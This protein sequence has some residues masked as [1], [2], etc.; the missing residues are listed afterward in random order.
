M[1]T[2]EH[3]ALAL[4]AGRLERPKLAATP[5]THI[6]LEDGPGL[7]AE[8]TEEGRRDVHFPLHPGES[9]TLLVRQ[10]LTTSQAIEGA[11]YLLAQLEALAVEEVGQ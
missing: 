9:V 4:S 2:T 8:L 5:I 6:L 11:R 1:S 3:N 7:A 10:G